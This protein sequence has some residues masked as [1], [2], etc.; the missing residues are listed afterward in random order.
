MLDVF[1][2]FMPRT[3]FD[4][5]AGLIPGHPVLKAFPQLPALLD[6][7]AR[8]RLL[9]AFDGLQQVIS[10]ANPP[11]EILGTPDQTP[12]LAREANDMLA[13]VCRR[14]PDRFQGFVAALPLNN[15][16][17]SVAEALRAVTQL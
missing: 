7:D 16:G 9:D 10:L 5:L 15:V 6:L 1:P 14:H 17:A 12:A 4:N 11:I 13:D 3:F 8:L 2:Q